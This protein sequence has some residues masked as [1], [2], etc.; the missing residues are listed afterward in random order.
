M[1]KK[2]RVKEYEDVIKSYI[3]STIIDP[4]TMIDDVS[5]LLNFKA[6]DREEEQFIV[7]ILKYIYVDAFYYSLNS[8]IKMNWRKDAIVISDYLDDLSVR[9]NCI[10]DTPLSH[11][12]IDE[13][14]FVIEEAK[15]NS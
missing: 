15:Q 11:K 1:I 14:L 6:K 4:E 10:K 12:F 5:D 7:M 3:S 9:V 8:S 2:S 13:A